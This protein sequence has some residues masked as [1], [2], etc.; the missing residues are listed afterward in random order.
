MAAMLVAAVN[1]L[2]IQYV[3]GGH[4]SEG[5]E[6]TSGRHMRQRASAGGQE[7]TEQTRQGRYEWFGLRMQAPAEYREGA[8]N[9][10]QPLKPAEL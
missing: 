3:A 5:Q 4:Q 6:Q 9:D 8:A 2:G 7:Q 1:G 10:T